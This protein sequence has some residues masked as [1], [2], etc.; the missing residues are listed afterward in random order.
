MPP[1]KTK[2]RDRM[3][4]MTFRLPPETRDKVI[5]A[6]IRLKMKPSE[7]VRD[8]IDNWLKEN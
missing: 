2:V 7:I 5:Q 4:S 6:S 1:N 3:R 8:L